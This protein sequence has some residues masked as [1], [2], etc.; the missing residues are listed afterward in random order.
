[1]VFVGP[2]RIRAM[3]RD[4]RGRDYATDVLSFR[5]DGEMDDDAPFLGELILAP[6]VASSHARCWRTTTEREIRKLLIHG[7]LHLL[8]YD[9]E[10]DQGE[11]ERL[12]A[13]LVRRRGT[14][15]SRIVRRRLNR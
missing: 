5:Y 6:E 9:H 1:V 2:D 13:R 8:G 11:M 7:I 4:Y 12:Q 3:N 14:A 10:R 15:G